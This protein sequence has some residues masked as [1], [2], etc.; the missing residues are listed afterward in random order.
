RTTELYTLSLHDALPISPR[1]YVIGPGDQILIDIYGKSE[2]DHT[3]SVSPE[4]TINIPYIGI[5]SV[6]GMTMEQATARIE[7]SLASVYSAI[8]RK[9]TRLNSS[10]LKI[11]Y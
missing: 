9:S 3:L 10:H 5:V 6:G 7:S 11:S 8:D 4:G 1:S 2:E